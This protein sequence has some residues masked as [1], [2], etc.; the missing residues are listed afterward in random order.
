MSL[1]DEMDQLRIAEHPKS[2]LRTSDF[3]LRTLQC[4]QLSPQSLVLVTL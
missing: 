4:R 3:G 1:E 2:S